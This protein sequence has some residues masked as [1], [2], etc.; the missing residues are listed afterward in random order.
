MAKDRARSAIDPATETHIFQDLGFSSIDDYQTWCVRNRI[1][2]NVRKSELQRRQEREL[3]QRQISE[4]ALQK[5]RQ[6][7]NPSHA[8]TRIFLGE[9]DEETIADEPLRFVAQ[10]CRKHSAAD[11]LRDYL[12]HVDSVSKVLTSRESTIAV[13]NLYR[14]RSEWCRDFQE[15]KP[16]SHNVEKQVASLAEH[17]LCEYQPPAFMTSV[18]YQKNRTRQRWYIHLGKGGSIRTAEGVPASL[19]KRMAHWFTQAPDQYTPLDAIRYGQ[20]CALGGDRRIADA[21]LSTRMA[22]DF[23]DDPFCLELIRFFVRNPMLDTSHYQPIVDFIWNQ[24]YLNQALFVER[25]VVDEQGPP[26]PGLSMRGRTPEGLLRQVED[27]HSRLGRT[28]KG[29]VLQWIRSG[30]PEFEWVEG[31]KESQNMCVWRIVELLSSRE[32]EDE[33]RTLGHCVATYASSCQRRISSIW[34]LRRETATGTEFTLTIELDV[35]GKEIVQVRGLRNRLPDEKE[36][37]VL[38]RWARVAGL[39]MAA[40]IGR[41]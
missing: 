13:L 14:Y 12:M 3:H 4:R 16:R 6:S 25:G 8:I 37:K 36:R 40:W 5:S 41:G 23:R 24:K 1:Q 31:K 22:Q 10:A 17:L 39:T 11:A 38:T 9:L 30:I 32:L 19:T 26:Q 7:H 15:W 34:S 33:G 20:V 29:D 18:W 2:S 21:L 28:A 35:K 27:W